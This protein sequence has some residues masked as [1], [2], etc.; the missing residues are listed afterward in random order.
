MRRMPKSLRHRCARTAGGSGDAVEARMLDHVDD[1]AHAAAFLA[2]ALRK[3]AVIL[4]FGRCVR[5]IAELV[6]KPHDV[7]RIA[8]PVRTPAR[9][10]KAGDPGFGLRER[11]K[12]VAH[13]RGAKPF[14]PG[15]LIFVVD[16]M[17]GDSGVGA[18]IRAALFFSHRHADGRGFLV[19]GRHEMRI[20]IACENARDPLLR[21]R[22]LM[23]QRRHR[24]IGH[25]HWAADTRFRA[26]LHEHHRRMSGVAARLCGPGQRGKTGRKAQLHQMMIGGMKLDFVEAVAIAV[27]TD[28]LRRVGVRLPR[29]V[30]HLC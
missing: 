5:A 4:N 16:N 30:D 6:F 8:R 7:K 12:R 28:K 10:Q 9:H 14:V 18:N 13:R 22:R 24:R 29:P 19:G 3:G 21:D 17:G 1:G 26:G 11:Q 27:E 15:Q 25:S 20:V 23:T 2:D